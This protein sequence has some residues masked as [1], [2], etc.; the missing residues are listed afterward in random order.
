MRT[1]L[2]HIPS[3]SILYFF[4]VKVEHGGGDPRLWW[5]QR[6]R[7]FLDGNIP[8]SFWT[9]CSN[10]NRPLCVRCSLGCRKRFCSWWISY[11]FD[12]SEVVYFCC[13][14][15]SCGVPCVL[16]HEAYLFLAW[17]MCPISL[18]DLEVFP[19]LNKIC[20]RG[21]SLEQRSNQIWQHMPFATPADLE[22][23]TNEE[24][25]L[26]GFLRPL[27]L[28]TCTKESIT[29]FVNPFPEKK[30]KEKGSLN[31]TMS[32]SDSNWQI[33]SPISSESS[34]SRKK[35]WFQCCWTTTSLCMIAVDKRNCIDSLNVVILFS[36]KKSL[37]C[38]LSNHSLPKKFCCKN[39]ANFDNEIMFRECV[40]TLQFANMY[41][42]CIKVI[43]VKIM[44]SLASA[45]FVG[46]VPHAMQDFSL[47]TTRF[48]PGNWQQVLI[49]STKFEWVVQ[50]KKKKA[51]HMSPL[52]KGHN[53][54]CNM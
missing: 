51:F 52:K 42:G 13:S 25:R 40:H 16:I 31:L 39:S 38:A 36:S 22:C 50:L 46:N 12:T 32:A 35:L 49:L 47:C 45:A 11:V 27:T 26:S 54:S 41:T 15:D 2:L 28:A 29:N 33:P 24:S 8:D 1:I 6:R 43:Y 19:I 7:F 5:S 14:G 18:F 53:T 4:F 20:T 34:K 9:A 21:A 23:N 30:E 10:Q 3:L 48:V 17:E 37:T 44:T